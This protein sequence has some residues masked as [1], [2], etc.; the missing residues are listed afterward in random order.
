MLPCKMVVRKKEVMIILGVYYALYSFYLT[1][2]NSLFDIV[3]FSDLK[4]SY[5]IQQVFTL[6]SNK[7]SVIDLIFLCLNPIKLNN[8]IIISM[9]WYLSNHTP[10]T[11]NIPIIEEFIQDECQTIIR[12]SKEEENFISKLVRAIENIDILIIP[13]KNSFE[14]IVQ[15][16]ANILEFIW[17]KDVWWVNIT[18]WYKAW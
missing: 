10:L 5:S 8:H 11:V 2:S 12:N 9:L 16:Y 13:D 4:L 18:K 15:E 17:Y 7:N 1:H 6:Y 14:L 3:N